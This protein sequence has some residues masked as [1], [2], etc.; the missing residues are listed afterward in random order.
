MSLPRVPRLRGP[1]L[2]SGLLLALLLVWLAPYWAPLRSIDGQWLDWLAAQRAKSR[3]GA[4]DIV[5]ID[6]D[7]RSFAQLSDRL[8]AWPWKRAVYGELVE[9]LNAQGARAIAF[10]IVFTEPDLFD[11]QSDGYFSEVLAQ[12]DNVYLPVIHLLADDNLSPALTRYPSFRG[13]ERGTQGRDDARASLLYPAVGDPQH[14]KLGTVNFIVDDDGIGRRYDIWRDIGGWRLYSLPSVIAQD[15]GVTLPTQPRI[16]LDWLGKEPIFPRHAF[17]DIYSRIESGDAM[18]DLQGKIV[19]IGTTANGLHDLRPTPLN[20]QYPAFFMLAT[21]LDNLRKGEQLQRLPAGLQIAIGSILLLALFRALQTTP[22]LL[23]L[24]AQIS[25]VSV[26]LLAS[27]WLAIREA[28][29]APVLV[30]L[31]ANVM[32]VMA[33]AIQRYRD[34]E[35]ARRNA[36]DMFGRFLDPNVVRQ[37]ARDGLPDAGELA[38]Q[39]TITILFS[40]IRGFT[41]LSETQ[42]PQQIMTL[43]NDYFERQVAVIFRHGGTLDKFI[44]DAIMAFWNAPLDDPQHAG[45][46]V[47]A[48]LEM[49]EELEKFRAERGLTD[50]DVGIGI[51]SGPAV[52]GMLGSE[53]RLDYTAIGDTVN[54]GSRLEGLTKGIARVLISQATHDACIADGSAEDFDFRFCGSYKVK[55]RHEEV[56]TW[57][58]LR[59][60]ALPVAADSAAVGTTVVTTDATTAVTTAGAEPASA[61]NA[62]T[63]VQAAR[64]NPPQV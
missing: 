48:A 14:W 59:R 9:W 40:D 18:P 22:Q 58:P 56:V 37:L 34:E 61:S 8:G 23:R 17:V 42:S 3:Q 13:L 45:N 41:T 50:F 2:W 30:T 12:Y 44:G 64:D 38:Q 16:L 35:D 29:L 49:V 39:R 53:Q 31:I 27:S 1:F 15:L 55:G 32:L 54:L 24:L 63:G 36:I 6:I 19:F 4:D 51:H 46:A 60:G 47:R 5:L 62:A 33:G 20:A 57:E 43:L 21:A 52:V 25:L 28:W 11:P 10:D 7:E 26:L